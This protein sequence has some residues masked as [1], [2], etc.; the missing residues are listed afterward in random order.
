MRASLRYAP[1]DVEPLRSVP[2]RNRT[3]K[4]SQPGESPAGVDR[5]LDPSQPV[6][7]VNGNQIAKPSGQAGDDQRKDIY[8]R[9]H[10][11]EPVKPS[12]GLGILTA[13]VDEHIYGITKRVIRKP[14]KKASAQLIRKSKTKLIAD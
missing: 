7:H 5:L 4:R 2:E 11:K 9:R 13:K 1:V 10:G 3:R 12:E 6:E 8:K 14:E